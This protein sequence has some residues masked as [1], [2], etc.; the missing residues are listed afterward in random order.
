MKYKN[1]ELKR[2]TKLYDLFQKKD[3]KL[4]DAAIKEMDERQKQHLSRYYKL[5]EERDLYQKALQCYG[6]D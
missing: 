6:L 3:M 2:G 1:L 5:P 4:L